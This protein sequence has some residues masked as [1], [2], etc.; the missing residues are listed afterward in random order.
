MGEI[1]LKI[2]TPD[3]S[4]FD[5]QVDRLIVRG[6]EGDLAILKGRAPIVT[7]LKIGKVRIFQNDVEKV[8]AVTDGYISSANN[9]ITIVT[10]AAEWPDEIDVK[11]AE[12]AKKKAEELLNRKEGTDVIR[13]QAALKRS[14]NR[15]ETSKYK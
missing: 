13:A 8:A 12:E 4:F 7:P 14:L 10:D 6:L 2:V 1:H 3:G 5:D 9:N 15:L 11:R